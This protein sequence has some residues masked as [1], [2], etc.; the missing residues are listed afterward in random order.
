M[1][2]LAEVE[3]YR[4]QW[5]PGKGREV[6]EVALHAEKRIF[7]CTD[8]RKLKRALTGARLLDSEASGKQ[9]LFRFSQNGWLGIHLGMTG[10]LRTEGAGFE[11]G[12]HDH[13]VLYQRGQALVFSDMRQFGLVRFEQSRVAPEWWTSIAPA[14][15]S[16]EF[17]LERM[18]TFLGAHGRLPVKA[19]LLLQ[20]GFP[21]VGN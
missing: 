18:Q 6:K 3:Y 9:M 16:R 19:A 8:T 14:V 2:E 12:K 10:N 13:L 7:R 17:T 11:P 15:T 21:G 1:P 4:K 20:T 5:D